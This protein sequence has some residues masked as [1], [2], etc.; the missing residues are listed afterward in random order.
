MDMTTKLSKGPTQ[1]DFQHPLALEK[2]LLTSA[3]AVATPSHTVP[4]PGHSLPH[5]PPAQP[6][7]AAAVVIMENEN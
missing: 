1:E 7:H 3:M 4:Q 2:L 6:A 5:S